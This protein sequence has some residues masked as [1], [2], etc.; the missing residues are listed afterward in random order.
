MESGL[1]TGGKKMEIYTIKRGVMKQVPEDFELKQ[2]VK[3]LFY[4][5]VGLMIGNY[6]PYLQQAA[7]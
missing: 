6:W 3:Y 5:I 2:V 4:F 7:N 1:V